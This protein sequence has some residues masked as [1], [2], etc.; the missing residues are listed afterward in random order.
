MIDRNTSANHVVVRTF[1]TM[2]VSNRL[3]TNVTGA[4]FVRRASTQ[5]RERTLLSVR[6]VTTRRIRT[7]SVPVII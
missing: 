4:E 3:A 6:L 7:K 2:D 5:Q 1:A